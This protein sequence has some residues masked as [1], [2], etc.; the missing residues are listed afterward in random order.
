MR[1][2][3]V[4]DEK[5]TST[6][7][8]MY[9]WF[10]WFI[11]SNKQNKVN[12]KNFWWRIFFKFFLFSRKILMSDFQIH[13]DRSYAEKYQVWKENV[14]FLHSNCCKTILTL[15]STLS[16]RML[17]S[18]VTKRWFHSIQMGYWSWTR[19]TIKSSPWPTP[20]GRNWKLSFTPLASENHTRLCSLQILV[21]TPFFWYLHSSSL[22]EWDKDDW[23]FCE[24]FLHGKTRPIKGK[25]LL[26]NQKRKSFLWFA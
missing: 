18:N 3:C 4:T 2:K 5:L 24:V 14:I 8:K 12:Q 22:R 16:I 19:F 7:K 17:S 23:G 1:R 13:F 26:C 15:V 25:N 9:F 20:A 11:S 10:M 21:S 6:H